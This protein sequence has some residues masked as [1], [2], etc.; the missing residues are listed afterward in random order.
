[1]SV[2]LKDYQLAALD[3]VKNGC[4]LKGGVGSGK[5]LTGLAWY[6]IE[7]GGTKESLS[8]VSNFKVL[9]TR[10]LGPL[11]IITTARKRDTKEWESELAKFGIFNIPNKVPVFVIDSWNNIQKYSTVKDV[12]FIF[13]EQR[14]VGR[15]KWSKTFIKIAKANRWIL[16]SATPGDQ[17]S[18]YI[19][20]FIA[21]GFYRNR[22]DFND[23]HVIWNP[24]VPYQQILKYY[25]TPQLMKYKREIVIPMYYKSPA[26]SHHEDIRCDYDR[27]AYNVIRRDRWNAYE[28]RPVRTAG[29]YCQLLRR[30][31]NSDKTRQRAFLGLLEGHP[32]AIVFYTY[33]YERDIISD[34]IKGTDYTLAEWNGFAHQPIPTTDKW[35]YLVQYSAGAEGWNCTETDTIIFYDESYSFKQMTQAA[36]RIDRQNTP[37]KDLYYF[38]LTSRSSIDIAIRAALSEKKEF[39]ETGFAPIFRKETADETYGKRV[40]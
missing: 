13:D 7:M 40:A 30:C 37:F 23:R 19:P 4:V 15:G 32:K 29:E 10:A 33:N 20:L 21:N 31:V 6:Y 22:T 11:Y 18:D 35:V 38:H 2:V 28:A 3:R 9:P 39:N 27:E 24:H 1:M 34:I 17:W 8:G 25:N 12:H 14:A 5:S 26:V 36:G 16:L